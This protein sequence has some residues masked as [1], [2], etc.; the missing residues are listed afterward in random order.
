[1]TEIKGNKAVEDAAVAWVVDLERQAG[2]T[3]S[4]RS[5]KPDLGVCIMRKKARVREKTV[6]IP[7]A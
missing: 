5:S 7:V 3:P 2:P 4:Q 1:M 6:P